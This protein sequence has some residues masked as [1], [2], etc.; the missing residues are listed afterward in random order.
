E[1]PRQLIRETR[2]PLPGSP[3]AVERFDY[4]YECCGVCNIFM[5]AE[6]LASKRIVQIKVRQTKTDWALFLNDVAHH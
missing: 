4:E 6:P 1:S 2:L 5:A 3:G